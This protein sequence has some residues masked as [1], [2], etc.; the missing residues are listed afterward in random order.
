MKT[1]LFF[2]HYPLM[3]HLETELEL[4]QNEI[5]DGNQLL[6]LRC[7][8]ALKG[9]TYNVEGSRLKCKSCINRIDEAIKRLDENKIE[10]VYLNKAETNEKHQFDTIENLMKY[11]YKNH[12][13]GNFV[14]STLVSH[15]RDHGFCTNKL[16]KIISNHINAAESIIDQFEELSNKRQ[17]DNVYIFNGRFSTPHSILA[18]C[19]SKR[20]NYFI[21]ER[22]GMMDQYWLI[23]NAIPHSIVNAHNEMQTLW[24]SYSFEEASRI[25]QSFFEDRRNKVIQAWVSFAAQQKNDYLKPEILAAKKAGKSIISIYTSSV[26][27]FFSIDEFRGPLALNQAFYLKQLFEI[28]KNDPNLYF[29]IREHPNL[30]GLDNLQNREMNELKG[31]YSNVCIVSS[32]EKVDSYSLMDISEAVITFGSTIG[33]EATYWGKISILTGPTF[34]KGLDAVYE[35]ESI[36]DVED[37][38]KNLGTL[39]PKPKENVLKYGLWEYCRGRSFKHVQIDG[40]FK[41]RFKQ[42]PIKQNILLV[43][44]AK[45]VDKIYKKLKVV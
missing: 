31:V 27:E 38:L 3:P 33:I 1:S 36:E 42:Y 24:N 43:L 22:G 39:L 29:V 7:S 15:Y 34:Y 14:V 19:Q 5:E 18:V 25:G 8:G 21:H 40:L 9:C 4:M 6:V 28:F 2:L 16:K 11:T 12:R 35:A 26:D 23:E 32:D 41:A 17:L 30:K 13:V 20:I 37:L 44:L 45:S 10:Q